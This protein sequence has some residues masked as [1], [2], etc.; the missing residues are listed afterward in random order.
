MH[1]PAVEFTTPGSVEAG[2]P[3]ELPYSIRLI[4]VHLVLWL[5]CG[6]LV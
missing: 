2:Y 5:V 4:F 1:A 6:P 3:L